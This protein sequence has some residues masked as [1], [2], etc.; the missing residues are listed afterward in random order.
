MINRF[1]YR[2]D[3]NR[4]LIG[5]LLVFIGILSPYLINVK[6][7]GIYDTLF[8]CLDTSNPVFLIYATFKLVI[9]N[10]LR[11]LPNYLS[12]FMIAEAIEI[13]YEK[14]TISWLSALLGL[15]IIPIAYFIIGM[16]FEVKYHLGA[17]AFILI[18]SIVLIEKNGFMTIGIFKKSLIMILLLLGVQWLDIMPLLTKHGFGSGEMSMEIKRVAEFLNSSDTLTLVSFVFFVIF[19]I[20]TY[21]IF[22]L[23]KDQNEL[24]L[25][26][27]E[28]KRVEKELAEIRMQ[29]LEARTSQ[30]IQSL[31]HDLKTPLTSIQALVSVSEMMVVD[32]KIGCYLSKINKSVDQLSLMISEILFEDKKRPITTDEL[33]EDI[34]SH[35]STSTYADKIIFSNNCSNRLLSVNK[36]RFSR[37][38]INTLNNSFDAIDPERGVIEIKILE[39]DCSI[40][41]IVSDNGI[42]IK[43]KDVDRVWQKGFSTKRSSGI[44]LQFVKN[45]IENHDGNIKIKSKYNVGT[46]ITIFMPEVIRNEEE[47]Y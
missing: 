16:L 18:I 27:E 30:E 32:D 4:L 39:G 28:N 7:I 33:F 8:L 13:Q 11:A 37:A 12:V 2:I 41:I 44:G 43:E 14:K 46:I 19:I 10:C 20:F 6:N 34:F 36:I 42:G 23:L 3:K 1:S 29:T 5:M 17:P 9:L 22:K 47:G 25:A 38:I 26:V 35:I 40:G 15:F 31:V 45:V 24:M 21:L